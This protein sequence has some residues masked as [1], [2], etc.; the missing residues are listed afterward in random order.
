MAQAQFLDTLNPRYVD[1]A[2]VFSAALSLFLELA[3][4]RWQ[5]SV[6]QF[7]AFYKNFSLLA[8]FAGLGWAMRWLRARACR[9]CWWPHSWP[10]SSASC[11]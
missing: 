9:W 7:L 4:I 8:C 6:L 2:I 5:S 1:V 3:L 10:Y 11:S